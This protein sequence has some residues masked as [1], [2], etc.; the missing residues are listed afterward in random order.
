MTSLSTKYYQPILS[1]SVCSGIGMLLI[2]TPAMNAPMTHSQ[3]C[4]AL[5]GGFAFPGSSLGGVVSLFMMNHLL[6]AIGFAWTMRACTFLILGLLLITCTLMSSHVTHTHKEFKLSSYLN[7]C[8]DVT[9][10]SCASPASSWGMFVPYVYMMISSIHYGMSV[11][12]G[13]NLIPILNG[14]R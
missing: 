7:R 4:R 8:G 5:A 3:N 13:Y 11:Q 9:F 10:Y 2:I 6:S 14:V 12:I 1:Q